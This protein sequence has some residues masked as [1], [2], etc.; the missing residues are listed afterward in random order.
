MKKC[1]FFVLFMLAIVVLVVPFAHAG[2]SAVEMLRSFC[3]FIKEGIGYG[4]F[5]LLII[6]AVTC[7]FLGGAI[8]YSLACKNKSAENR[9]IFLFAICV[10]IYGFY[11]GMKGLIGV[12]LATLP[13]AF[14]KYHLTPKQ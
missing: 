1:G 3:E 7:P 4:T 14:I 10:A 13:V 8:G 9:F 5:I 6:A 11:F 12:A 2:E